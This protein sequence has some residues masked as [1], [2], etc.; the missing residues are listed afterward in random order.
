M[1]GERRGE[2]MTKR[3]RQFIADMS[4]C[5]GMDWVRLGMMV[6]VDGEIGTIKGM[7]DSANLDIVFANQLKMGSGEHNCHPQWDICYFN[8]DGNIIA[9]YRKT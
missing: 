9:D 8:T 7:N 5:R 6:E 3:E 1:R 2:I 4:R